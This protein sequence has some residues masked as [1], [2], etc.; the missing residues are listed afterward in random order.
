MFATPRHAR[1]LVIAGV[2][3]LGGTTSVIAADRVND[4]PLP[5]VDFTM[6]SNVPFVPGVGT[7][8]LPA[9][10]TR[11][12]AEPTS[13]PVLESTQG[14]PLDIAIPQDS[15]LGSSSLRRSMYV[16]FAALQVMDAMSTRKALSRGATEANPMMAG[17]VRNNAALFAVKAGTAAAAAY[18]SERLAKNHPRRAMILM[19][20]LNTAYAGIVAHNYRVA[21]AN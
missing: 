11:V 19:A 20:V 12:S 14:R 5:T 7:A 16:S 21:R 18:F 8:M 2:V 15:G 3:L 1:A 17:V 6:A 13:A 9:L 4:G 10:V